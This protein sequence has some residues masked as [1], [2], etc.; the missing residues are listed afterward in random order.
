MKKR[1]ILFFSCLLL[2][3]ASSLSQPVEKSQKNNTSFSHDTALINYYV[4]I[5]QPFTINKASLDSAGF[6]LQ[7]IYQL[8]NYWHYSTGLTEYYR[9]LTVTYDTRYLYDSAKLAI[10]KE[11]YWAQKSGDPMEVAEAFASMGIRYEYLDELDSAAAY[12]IRAVRISDSV[13]NHKFSGMVYNNIAILFENIGD[14]AKA[15]D[16]ALKGYKMGKLL[17]DT[18]ILGSCLINLAGVKKDLKQ[19]DTAMILYDQIKKAVAHADKYAR[20]IYNATINEGDIL[21]AQDQNAEALTKYHEV[22]EHRDKVS[23]YFLVYVYYGMGNAFYKMKQYANAESNMIMALRLSTG[24]NSRQQIR[25]S[26][27][28]LSE[29]KEAQKQFASALAYRKKYDSLNDT[30]MNETSKKNIHLLEIK[31]NTAQKDKELTQQKLAL[32]EERRS[33]ERKNTWL[34]ISLIGL[35]ALAAILVLSVRNYRHKR[36][37]HLQSILTLQKQHEVNTLKARMEAREEERNRIG[38][39]MHD[40]IG[41]AL[42]TILYLSDDLKATSDNNNRHTAER[43]AGTAGSV[44]DKMNEIIWSMNKEYDTLDDLIAYTRQHTAEFLNNYGLE[45]D[46]DIPD[47]V[48]DIHL[49]GEQRRNI[50]LVI[51]ESLHNI[52]KHACATRVAISFQIKDK[53]IITIHDNGKGIPID[54]LRRFGNGL[55][56]MRQRMESVGGTFSIADRSGTLITLQ[57]VLETEK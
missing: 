15:T 17:N 40:D 42:T 43:I 54:G 44:V 52:V 5:V 37:L 13:K 36:K 8:S 57:C 47:I 27:Q 11:Y 21:S 25:D 6:Y 9:L 12:Y 41:S 46:F 29:I 28:S 48:P 19:Y 16:Y 4:N 32:S 35:M 22:L 7:K 24:I 45:Y 49:P 50:Y 2:L 10:Q 56:N 26:Y 23:P 31:Y 39:E 34:L 30:L 14:Y 18:L 20:F 1:L 38:Q 53:L 3:S 33:I 55:R 51:K